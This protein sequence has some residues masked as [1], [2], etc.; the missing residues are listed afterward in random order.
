MHGRL[1]VGHGP[2]AQFSPDAKLIRASPLGLC[3]FGDFEPAGVVASGGKR[4]ALSAWSQTGTRVSGAVLV[5]ALTLEGWYLLLVKAVAI[6]RTAGIC[7][8]LFSRFSRR[9]GTRGEFGIARIERFNI[10]R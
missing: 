10:Q 1:L 6:S 3:K 9:E 2:R 5:Y 4:G 7:A 8:L